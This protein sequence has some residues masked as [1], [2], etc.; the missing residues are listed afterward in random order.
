[1]NRKLVEIVAHFAVFLELADESEIPIRVAVREQ[2]E[3][4][5]KLQKLSKEERDEF[6]QLLHEIAETETTQERRNVINK[7]PENTGLL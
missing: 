3:L 2:E 5:F 6:L 4:A 1:M 7:I